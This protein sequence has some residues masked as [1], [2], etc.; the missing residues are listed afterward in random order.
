MIK[1][2]NTALKV[3]AFLILLGALVC[4]YISWERYHVEKNATTVELSLI[5]I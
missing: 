2:E 5:H 3:L 1:V 4:G